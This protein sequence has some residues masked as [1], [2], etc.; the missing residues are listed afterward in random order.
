MTEQVSAFIEQ[1]HLRGR[2]W[3]VLLHLCSN[4]LSMRYIPRPYVIVLICLCSRLS[5]SQ[6]SPSFA[7]R[8][9]PYPNPGFLGSSSHVAIFNQISPEEY[10]T[11]DNMPSAESDMSA[12]MQ[13]QSSGENILIIQGADVLRQLFNTFPLAAMK[14]FIMFWLET[15]ANMSLAEPFV[16]QCTKDMSRLFTTF[17]QEENWHLAYAQRLTQNSRA[18][19]EIR[20]SEISDF[21][22]QFLDQNFRWESL[23]IFLSAVTRATIAVSF[24]PPLYKTEKDRFLLR[25]MCTSLSDLALDIVFSLDCLND[26]QLVFQYEN[27]IVHTH[28]DGDQS[29]SLKEKA[30]GKSADG[31]F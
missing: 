1:P 28:V 13:S 9:N 31:I 15:G 6:S 20:T 29:M 14:N 30:F 7:P 18:P 3:I 8:N 24:F 19:L 10:H 22:A 2:E 4:L 17:T 16:E 5:P 11:P 25:K 27:F 26:I 21:S 23:G 12:I